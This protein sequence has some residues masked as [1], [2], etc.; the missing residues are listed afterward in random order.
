MK[1]LLYL[2]AVIMLSVPAVLRAWT[3]PD[4][5][6]RYEVRFKWGFIDANAGVA[7]LS[8]Y[9]IPGTNQFRATLTGKS[10]DLL[11]HYYAAGDTIIGTLMSDT[12]QSVYTEHLSKSAG[13][14]AIQTIT[15]PGA[16]N[17]GEG[18]VVKTL[19][20]GRVLRERISHYGGGVT[21]DLLGVFY[22][23]RQLDYS[24]MPP[25]Q[26][27]RVNIFSGTDAETLQVH[28]KGTAAA[29]CCGASVAA[30]NVSLTFSNNSGNSAP[31]QMD[32][33]ISTDDSRIPISVTGSL[34]V[35]H[36]YARFIGDDPCT[37]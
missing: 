6:L 29:D 11:G 21:V 33:L 26:M 5:T 4:E 8:T 13:E 14:F 2:M 24:K 3:V 27:V 30:Y 37:D 10:V 32:V 23:I 16:G 25:G 31:S 19:P 34:K 9:N 1:R 17:N 22:Y 15:Y 7:E 35:G 20:G 18:C 36:I 12:V 28:Y